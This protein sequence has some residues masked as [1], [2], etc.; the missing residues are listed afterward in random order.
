[1]NGYASITDRPAFYDAIDAH[2]WRVL[3]GPHNIAKM[4]LDK[5]EAGIAGRHYCLDNGAWTAHNSG[6]AWD[7]GA[8]QECVDAFGAGA[9][10]IVC[11]DIVCGGLE[12]LKLTEEWLPRLPG[13][14]L[15]AVQNGHTPD[16]IRDWLGPEVGIFVGGDD[17]WKEPSLSIW[18]ELARETSCYLHV[19]RMNSKR[20]IR[21]CALAGADSFDGTSVTFWPSNI[22]HLDAER[23]QLTLFNTE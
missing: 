12:S 8:F 15:V 2:G 7:P 10:F 11:P 1:M 16:D 18:G 13:L 9:D 23:Q 17:T 4:R 20:K 3:F 21:L 22:R 14:R 6:S 5:I 19:G